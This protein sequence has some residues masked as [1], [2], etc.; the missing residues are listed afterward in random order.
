MKTK[1]MIGTVLTVIG[2][3]LYAY[4]ILSGGLAGAIGVRG[5]VELPAV[6]MVIGMYAVLLGPALWFG[7]VPTAIKKFIEARTGR[8]LS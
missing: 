2:L 8:K 6:A 7:E 3:I 1:E 5:K 4:A